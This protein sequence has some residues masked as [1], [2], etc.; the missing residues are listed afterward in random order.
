MDGIEAAKLVRERHPDTRV[1]ALSMLN[2]EPFVQKIMENGAS[3]YILKTTGKAELL[4]SIKLVAG[5]NPFM[6]ADLAMRLLH[7][8]TAAGQKDAEG[9]CSNPASLT[10]R[11]IEVLFL[12]SEGYTNEQIADKLFNSKRTI[13]TH[14]Q[15]ILEKTGARNT[16]GLVKYA[17]QN[18]YIH[19][20]PG[21]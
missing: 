4:S 8:S 20:G 12:V 17:I 5:G 11:E 13:E 15:N 10:S 3:G 14:R 2:N 7:N 21:D 6:G 9:P 19:V 1:L 18:G 16:A